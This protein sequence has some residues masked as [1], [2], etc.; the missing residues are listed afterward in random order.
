VSAPARAA[1]AWAVASVWVLA[2]S[3]PVSADPVP[4]PE[5]VLGFRP[6][7]DY[8]LA[9]YAT[10]VRYFRA[11]DDASERVRL[12]EIGPSAEGR[13]MIAAVITSEA[14]QARLERIREVSRRLALARG[15][16]GEQARAL[17]AEGR[18]VVWIDS[19]LHATEVAHAQH[20]PE[21]AYRVATEESA[22]MR[23]IRDEVVLV[24]VP[25]MNPD[26][27]D[28]VAGWYARNLGTPY[29]VAPMVELYQKHAGHDNN[30]DWYMFNLPESRNVARLLYEEWLPQIV[31]NHHQTA[32]FPARIFVPPFADPMNPNIP[33]Q[34]MRGIHVV[35]DAITAR[36]EREGKV[37][38][39]SRSR[40][41]TWWNGGM[42]T[43]P[44]FHNMVGI[45]TE[46]ALW[47]YA[48][49]HRYDPEKLPKA[50][51]D[52]TP[53]DRP[54]T[55]YPSPWKGGWWR[56]RDAV[57]YMVSASLAVLDVG[58]RR[59]DEWLYGIY[60]M[61]AEAIEAGSKGDPFAYVMPAGQ[62][63]PGASRRLID[64]LRIG[65]VEVHRARAGF[66]AG[67]RRFERGS[68]VVLMAQPFR[69]HAKD[70]L[71]VQR[72]PERRQRGSDP[73]PPYDIS[74]WTL[75]A[76]MGVEAVVVASPFEAPLEPVAAAAAAGSVEG[77]GS[78][79][80]V[81]PRSND[82]FAI[83]NRVL[84]AGG[85]VRRARAAFRAGGRAHEVGT[86][87]LTGGLERAAMESAVRARGLSVVAV[88]ALPANQGDLTRLLPA[89]RIGVY[90]SWVPS[91]DEG[92]TRW[93][94]E[95]FEFP[96][97]SL[98]DA[99]V[100]RGGLREAFDVIVLPDTGI[101]ALLA[102]HIRGSVPPEFAGG[103]GLEGAL[104]LKRFV[105]AGG[106]L[107]ALDSAA[108]LASELFGLGVRNVLKG[109]AREDYFCPGGV[110]QVVVEADHPLAWGVPAR[111][112]VFAENGPAFEEE[113]PR[114]E[115]G[116]EQPALAA[117]GRP[118][119]RVVARFAEKDVLYSG[120]LLGE[121]RIAR[122]GALVEAPLGKGRVVLV[123]FRAQFRGQAHGTFK[124]LFN[125]FFPG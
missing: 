52:G 112:M 11:L 89:A 34:V 58:A 65:G 49:P 94:L 70:V 124:F 1:R 42:R 110:L 84:R 24:Q 35:G 119:P 111:T 10:I 92:W 21:L 31:Y 29:E 36:L 62:W 106:T 38:A 66:T 32:P 20:A 2:A 115:E 98:R 12:L 86:F 3:G 121:S 78:T 60:Q 96:F 40:F 97:R 64:A 68:H 53:A 72:Y 67:D 77:G 51:R 4:R 9:D 25:V 120:W 18:T 104:A 99:D 73:I 95:E 114:D 103:L 123:G 74:G 83:A 81:G 102:G 108:D 118:K 71:E 44:Y 101:R 48:T 100:R 45:L 63:D 93:V 6:G 39:V 8:K 122:K 33:P 23:R 26:G 15:L 61:G 46:T 19:G 85:T 5:D 88:D 30:R 56:L 116:E 125:V 54:T 55:F 22:E 13:T 80:L 27:L 75:P 117:T 57:D 28:L 105:E 82:A 43:A 59:R 107:V 113:G 50:F 16:T 90:R 79:Y 76:Q 17:A 69:A 91:A 7:T 37:G 47:R 87:V 14:N 109:V 41:D